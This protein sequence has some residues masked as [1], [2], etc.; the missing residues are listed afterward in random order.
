VG[1]SLSKQ[2]PSPLSG[3]QTAQVAGL[4]KK[5]GA[6]F[7]ITSEGKTLA[8]LQAALA[9]ASTAGDFAGAELIIDRTASLGLMPADLKRQN[10]LLNVESQ[11]EPTEGVTV[12]L[13]GATL[14]TSGLCKYGMREIAID[15]LEKG[16]VGLGHELI[17]ERLLALSVKGNG[18]QKGQ[19]IS[20]KQ[21]DPAAVLFVALGT[22]DRW[23][24]SDCDPKRAAPVPGLKKYISSRNQAPPSKSP[25]KS[26]PGPG[27]K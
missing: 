4:M 10:Q 22:D 13:A 6:C 8:P 9:M 18:L 3:P 21:N 5:L 1:D 20:Y 11:I 27:R 26:G 7:V 24:V 2:A 17:Y 15:S 14:T 12:Q 23:H 25:S 16:E 19:V